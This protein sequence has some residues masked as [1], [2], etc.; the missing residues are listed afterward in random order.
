MKKSIAELEAHLALLYIERDEEIKQYEQQIASLSLAQRREKGVAWHPLLIV[1]QGFALGEHGY[2]IV[3]RTR[4]LNQA[5]QF[6]AGNVVRIFTTKEASGDVDENEK[7]VVH[8][9]DKNRMKIILYSK[10]LPEW[11]ADGKIG[12]DI[13]FDD[14]SFRDMEFALND[15][16]KAENNRLYNLR[17][18][19][20]GYQKP[21]FLRESDYYFKPVSF[22]NDS[23]NE[24]L[25]QVMASLEVAV[26][27]GPPGTGKTTTLVQAIKMLAEQ[28][29]SKTILV[30]APSNAATDLLTERLAAIHLH[31]TRVGN[32]SRVDEDLLQYTLDSQLAAHPEAKH[33][34]RVRIE[35]AQARR[36]ANRF[37]RTF[38]H[39]E[40][41][42]RRNLLD[43]AK[44]LAAWA[45]ELEDKL[46][47]EVLSN[48]Q[49]ICCTLTGAANPL[50]R[51]R[52]FE[53]VVIDE[54]AQALEAAT[55]IP[56]RLAQ[57]V[58]LAGDPL[59]LPPTIKSIKAQ[60]E[61]LNITLLEKCINRFEPQN[62]AL[63]RTQYRMN[64]VIMGFSNQYFYEN[65]L[66]AAE[67]VA[68]QTLGWGRKPML[69]IDTVGCGFEEERTAE[70]QSR[71]NS[72]E[73]GIIREHL[74]KLQETYLDT[75]IPPIGIISPYKQQVN[76]IK[77]HLRDDTLLQHLDITVST[78]DG[79]QG[80][81]AEIIYI[82]LVRS[83]ETGEIGFLSD[84]RRMNV[85]LTR[86]KRKLV[87]VGD[88]GTLANHAFYQ[89][90]LDY[91]EKTDSYHSAWEWMA[92]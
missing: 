20:L 46:V 24:A 28:Q 39:E 58:V 81:E 62:V 71:Y 9:V 59:Q 3:E 13:L 31:V 70:Q 60:R 83:N 68:K 34:K 30:C 49:V 74:Y 11:L 4:E 35:A 69:F 47:E 8:F 51:S 41:S 76:Y 17:E 45:R 91:V 29:R 38:G 85:A 92:S 36:A 43:E 54:A 10:D 89:T 18:V 64:E 12:V 16:I 48:S 78:V 40:R 7:G 86:A 44:S 21:N 6:K 61:G 33:I 73:F 50:I 72:G 2:V 57:R 19:L 65:Q 55:W 14:R 32:V 66:F 56:I 25:R 27:H 63:L 80:Q 1:E 77:E 23:Q 82:S 37:R 15:V 87:V 79:F 5:H 53:V 90:F 26:I 42:E 75:P 84:F 22:L 67:S 88:S 52:K